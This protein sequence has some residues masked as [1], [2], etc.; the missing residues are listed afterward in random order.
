[1]VILADIDSKTTWFFI[2]IPLTCRFRNLPIPLGSGLSALYDVRVLMVVGF[3]K[4]SH[5]VDGFWSSI[6]PAPAFHGL[7]TMATFQNDDVP[8]SADHVGRGQV[9]P[10]GPS[11]NLNE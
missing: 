10:P 11:R 7:P 9:C 2:E 5:L 1:M 4:T 3:K 6:F 8:R